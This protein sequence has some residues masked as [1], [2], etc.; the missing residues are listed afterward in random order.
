MSQ[1]EGLAILERADSL[2]ACLAGKDEHRE[3][4]PGEDGVDRRCLAACSKW[5]ENRTAL[6]NSRGNSWIHK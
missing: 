1:A 3:R 6:N 2:V 5:L 4:H